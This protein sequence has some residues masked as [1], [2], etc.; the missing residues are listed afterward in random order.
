MLIEEAPRRL[1]QI[2]LRENDLKKL[3]VLGDFVSRHKPQRGLLTDADLLRVALRA[4]TPTAD[5]LP[6]VQQIQGEDLRRKSSKGH[7]MEIVGHELLVH[8]I[9]E[10]ITLK[11]LANSRVVAFFPVAEQHEDIK[12]H[13]LS[14]REDSKGNALAGLLSPSHVEFRWHDHYTAE[15]VRG[16][17]ER[18]TALAK[19]GDLRKKNVY[20]RGKEI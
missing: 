13:G 12:T 18:V 5:I 7:T 20:Y 10:G 19:A 4:V 15:D 9:A 14:F 6:L 2:M 16:I 8:A 1:I 11:F 17:W 3:E